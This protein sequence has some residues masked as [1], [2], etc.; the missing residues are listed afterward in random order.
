EDNCNSINNLNPVEN[1]ED[2]FDLL[3]NNTQ[4]IILSKEKSFSKFNE[5]NNEEIEN[6]EPLYSIALKMTFINWKKLDE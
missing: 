3:V 6:F 4:T 5:D 1:L 2:S